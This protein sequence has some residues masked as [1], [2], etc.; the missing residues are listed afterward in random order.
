[1]KSAPLGSSAPVCQVGEIEVA[2]VVEREI[3]RPL[4]RLP[5]VVAD[6][7]V[8][9]FALRLVRPHAQ[10]SVSNEDASIL[11]Q[12]GALRLGVRRGLDDTHYLVAF[13]ARQPSAKHFN[14][15]Q[16]SLIVEQGSFEE[17][18]AGGDQLNLPF[19]REH[20]QDRTLRAGR[21]RYSD[22]CHSNQRR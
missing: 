3:V 6:E 10:A 15:P 8:D 21:W 13:N 16:C 4:K 11:V 5:M 9:L 7:Q 18:A 1:M 19:L 20:L 22:N 17:L 14:Q 2:V 12:G